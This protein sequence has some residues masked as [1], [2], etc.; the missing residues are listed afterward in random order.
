MGYK[1]G[2][3]FIRVLLSSFMDIKK[4]YEDVKSLKIQGATNVALSVLEALSKLP[5]RKR[6]LWAKKFLEVR[7]TEPLLKN[8]I[9]YLNAHGFEKWEEFKALILEAREK[10]WSYGK[11]LLDDGMRVMTY[12]HSSTVTGFIKNSGAK[13]EVVV[14]E[15]R[16]KW[17]GRIT[18]KELAS[19]GFKV[20]FIVDA[21]I[22]NFV[23]DVDLVLIGADLIT[24]DGFI[25]NKIGS[26]ILALAAEEARTD[27]YVAASL[28]KFDPDSAKGKVEIEKRDPREVWEN[29][30]KNVKI[31]NP[32]FEFVP[33][34]YI[35][36]LI[37]ESGFTTTYYVPSLV[38]DLYPWMLKR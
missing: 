23:N 4:V 20:T 13:V 10:I 8:G 29:P 31:E 16:P 17:Q 7:P 35:H 1:H 3:K 2:K 30:P 24:A 25:V 37:T 38:E 6:S 18:A 32:A 33:P 27:L 21:A 26:G 36:S 15:T 5:P 9:R 12:C 28:L 19:A 14:C 22:R 34:K 11:N